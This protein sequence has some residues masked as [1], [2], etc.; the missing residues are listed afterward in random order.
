MTPRKWFQIL[1]EDMAYSLNWRV[2]CGNC[3][4]C[5]TT[6]TENYEVHNEIIV[7]GIDMNINNIELVTKVADTIKSSNYAR[8]SSF[9]HTQLYLVNSAVSNGTGEM[10][11]PRCEGSDE[12]CSIDENERSEHGLTK[13]TNTNITVPISSID[14]IF[15]DFLKY[16]DVQNQVTKLK[17]NNDLIYDK[18]DISIIDMLIIDTEGHDPL[19]LQ[20]AYN[21]LKSSRVRSLIFEYHGKI[22]LFDFFISL[23]Y[24]IFF[25]L[26]FIIG[27]GIWRSTPLK[28]VIDSLDE[29]N[30]QCFLAGTG[31]LWTI[32]GCFY[33]DWEFHRWYN[34]IFF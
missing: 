20:G 10:T 8:N 9:Y 17:N 14:I 28:E 1:D 33:H 25:A 24:L 29:F 34:I 11:I 3:N 12:A 18:K 4:D 21:L 19:V 32:T 30:Y 13:N 23:S 6:Y 31:K 16:I 15:D 22:N 5:F 2:S 7:L 27:I 26:L